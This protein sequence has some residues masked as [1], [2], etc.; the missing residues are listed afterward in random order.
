MNKVEVFKTEINYIKDDLY[1]NDLMYLIDG[2]PDYFFEIPAS[3]TGKYHPEYTTSKSGLV[4]HTKVVARIAKELIDNPCI[5]GKY[6]KRE[7][8]LMIIA[9]V[10]HDGLKSGNPKERYTRFDHPLLAAQYVRDN[11]ENLSMNDEDIEFIASVI[12]THMGPWIT[13]YN[14][15]DVLEPPKTKYQNFVHMCDYIASRKFLNVS[16]DEEENIIG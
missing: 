7:Q 8:D 16:F 1:R 15:V 2:L 12:E 11:K 3:S 9:C 10:L 5:G 4:R 14:G 13:D 6:T